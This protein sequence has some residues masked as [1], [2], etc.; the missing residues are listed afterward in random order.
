MQIQRILSAN[1]LKGLRNP[2]RSISKSYP[3]FLCSF[4]LLAVAVYLSLDHTRQ[5]GMHSQQLLHSQAVQSAYQQLSS[6]IKSTQMMSSEFGSKHSEALKKFLKE[7]IRRVP[8]DIDLLQQ[9]LEHDTAQLATIAEIQQL[10]N[11]NVRWM[12]RESTYSA[13]SLKSEDQVRS[14]IKMQRLIQKG[15][16]VE[17][18]SINRKTAQYESTER[19][20]H[21]STIA[22]GIIAIALVLA[23]SVSNLLEINRRAGVE[24]FTESVLKTSQSA[25]TVWRAIREKNTIVDFRAIFLNE[26]VEKNGPFKV[27]EMQDRLMSEISPDAKVRGS[28]GVYKRVTETGIQESFESGYEREN[29]K[30]WVNVSVAK[31]GDGCIVSFSDITRL[32]NS[33]NELQEKVELLEQTNSELEQFAYVASHDLQEPLRKIKT[34]SSLINE[35]FNE[36]AAAF[37]KVYLAKVIESA[38]RM[39]ALISDL[40][41][42]S[43][44]S[45]RGHSFALVDLNQVVKNVLN[46]FELVVEEKNAKISSE[47]LPVMEA[48]PSQMNQLFY[49][50]IGNALKYSKENVVPEISISCRQ[51][52]PEE[53]VKHSLNDQARHYSIVIRDNGIGFDPQFSKKIFVIFQRLNNR[54]R[55]AGTGIG[56]ALCRKIVL[57]HHGEIYA[58]STEGS[59]SAFHII[60]PVLQ[61]ELKRNAEPDESD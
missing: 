6:D 39:S 15:I 14:L 31:F 58:E 5:I 60:L 35:R 12:I 1:S 44:I 36:P 38:D 9:I 26:S 32:V 52:S 55:F 57:N 29:Q 45:E 11:E 51:A 19:K 22:L 56:L 61:K 30:R 37:A 20:L 27:T 47:D 8:K 24:S 18:S 42:L 10:F 23:I 28:F 17:A 33:Q 50:I 3:I 49:N 54:Q 21:L 16:N 53:L 34:F 4:L 40:L 13:D 25:I 46:D 48:I 7:D 41:S 2:I 43:Y 59:G